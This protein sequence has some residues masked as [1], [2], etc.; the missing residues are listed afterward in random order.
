M[1]GVP[2]REWFDLPRQV[3][4][5]EGVVERISCRYFGRKAGIAWVTDLSS[6][7][8]RLRDS[9]RVR[10]AP[11]HGRESYMIRFS[12]LGRCVDEMI[13]ENPFALMRPKRDDHDG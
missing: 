6:V 13:D 10:T 11:A 7:E 4:N 5:S 8:D 9:D 1:K 12:E 3:R 2:Y